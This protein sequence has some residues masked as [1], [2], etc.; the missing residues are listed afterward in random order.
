MHTFS[1]SMHKY[2][3]STLFIFYKF[4][5]CEIQ[6]QKAQQLQT[7]NGCQM[8]SSACKNIFPLPPV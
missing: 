8:Y 2:A 4:G 1:V 3:L 5:Y 7:A 6:P